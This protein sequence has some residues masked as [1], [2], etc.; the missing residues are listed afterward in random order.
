MK[1]SEKQEIAQRRREFRSACIF[2]GETQIQWAARH[3]LSPSYLQG[4]LYGSYDAPWVKE[5]IDTYIQKFKADVARQVE[6][7]VV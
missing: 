5:A 1:P 6:G 3:K 7:A 4:I 2:R